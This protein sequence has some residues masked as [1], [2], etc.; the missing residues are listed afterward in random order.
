MNL[1]CQDTIYT[2]YFLWEC[3]QK[4]GDQSSLKEDQSDYYPGK[5]TTEEYNKNDTMSSWLRDRQ[6][7]NWKQ[8]YVLLQ[9]SL[10]GSR[11]G[12]Y[13]KWKLVCDIVRT[14]I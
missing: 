2:L 7:H 10:T 12:Y 6:F 9:A 3:F 1:L 11:Q 8:V 13:S 5:Q 4:V 14:E